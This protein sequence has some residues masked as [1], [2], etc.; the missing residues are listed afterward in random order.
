MDG[1]E[2]AAIIAASSTFLATATGTVVAL[3]VVATRGEV[4]RRYRTDEQT[5]KPLPPNPAKP[6]GSVAN[7]TDG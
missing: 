1:L 3:R 4:T 6:A 7:E 5:S 2:V